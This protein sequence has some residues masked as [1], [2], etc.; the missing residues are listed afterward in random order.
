MV[1]VTNTATHNTSIHYRP[2]KNSI[3]GG[4]PRFKT[5]MIELAATAD[6]GDTTVVDIAQRW[7]MTRVLGVLGFIHT[8]ANSVVVEEAPVTAYDGTKLTI[9]VGGSTP[10]KQRMYVVYGI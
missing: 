4:V 9:T 6:N 10:N 5:G 3:T 7:G 2:S 1:A 8:T